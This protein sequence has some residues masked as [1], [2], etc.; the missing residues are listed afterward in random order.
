MKG[1]K[2]VTTIEVDED[3]AQQLRRLAADERRS[4]SEV[5]RKLVEGYT[6]QADHMSVAA[7]EAL[8][9]MAGMFDDP[10]AADLS[11]TVRETMAAFY[12][13]KHDDTD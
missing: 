1:N 3:I 8:A 13:R 7:D 6:T 10:D 2:C 5:M 11:V 9:A 4:V 12:R